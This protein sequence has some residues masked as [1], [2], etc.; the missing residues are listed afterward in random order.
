[1]WNELGRLSQGWKSHAGTDKIEL[2]FHKDKPKDKRVTYVRAVC[3][4]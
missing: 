1:M 2:I 4:I 3:D